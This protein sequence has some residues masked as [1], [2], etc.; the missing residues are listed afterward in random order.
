MIAT[1]YIS[2]PLA[3]SVIFFTMGLFLLII[4]QIAYRELKRSRRPRKFR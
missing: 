4:M 2:L 3:L 1:L